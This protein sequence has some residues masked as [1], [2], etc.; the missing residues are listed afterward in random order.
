MI[1]THSVLTVTGGLGI[2]GSQQIAAAVAGHLSEEGFHVDLRNLG[3]SGP[4]EDSLPDSVR[5]RQAREFKRPSR[6]IPWLVGGWVADQF[7][8]AMGRY[9]VVHSHLVGST[10]YALPFAALRSRP[11]VVTYHGA[12]SPMRLRLARLMAPFQDAIVAVSGPVAEMLITEG[13]L[14]RQKVHV[15]HNGIE[16]ADPLG[17]PSKSQSMGGDD[18]V[19]VGCIGHVAEH[20]G[21]MT[22]LE[23]FL[24]VRKELPSAQLMFVGDGPMLASLQAATQRLELAGS[25]G[26][27]GQRSD[28]RSLLQG[29]SV[30]VVPAKYEGFNLTILEAWAAGVP[31]VATAAGGPAELI[32][33][34]VDGF[35][36]PTEDP[37]AMG[38]GILQALSDESVIR[39]AREKFTHGFTS[40]V[41]GAEY[42]RLLGSLA[43]R[44]LDSA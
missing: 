41:M 18:A 23:A 26:F 38:R 42:S 17:Q 19:V 30:L 13:R 16:V 22:L 43:N 12:L 39:N 4:Y 27:L 33:N 34:G 32:A 28:A 20:K 44:K 24:L 36:V 11:W 8:I 9:S 7:R 37:D 40:E 31:V 15:I 21:Q 3:R 35:L 25:V 2:G 14:P 29:F 6:R 5:V 10:L 1:D